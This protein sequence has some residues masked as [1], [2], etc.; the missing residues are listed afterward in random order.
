M[1]SRRCDTLET[2]HPEKLMHIFIAVWLNVEG[3]ELCLLK[4][5]LWIQIHKNMQNHGF[6]D[7]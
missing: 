5:F 6:P 7:L 4:C 2:T 3:I 1:K